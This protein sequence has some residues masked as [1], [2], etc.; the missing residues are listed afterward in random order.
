MA[1]E[2]RKDGKL[3]KIELDFGKGDDALDD[4]VRFIAACRRCRLPLVFE[5]LVRSL[6]PPSF[7]AVVLY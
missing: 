1:T 5:L 6:P 3:E 4:M 2:C 7:A